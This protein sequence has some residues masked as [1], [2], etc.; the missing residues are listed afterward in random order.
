MPRPLEMESILVAGHA[1]ERAV[2][3][4][5]VRVEPTPLCVGCSARGPER[6]LSPRCNATSGRGVCARRPASG[7]RRTTAKE[8]NAGTGQGEVR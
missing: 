4:V 5:D 7:G 6:E 1:A 8:R 3:D 2:S